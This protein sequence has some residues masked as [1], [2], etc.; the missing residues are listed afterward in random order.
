MADGSH[1]WRLNCADFPIAAIKRPS[2]GIMLLLSIMKIC[3]NSQ[4][5]VFR[6]SQAIVAINPMSPMR[7]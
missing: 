6:L 2:N 5:F 1:G 7:L 3:W 4:E